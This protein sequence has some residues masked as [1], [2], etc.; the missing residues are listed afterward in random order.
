MPQRRFNWRSG[1]RIRSWLVSDVGAF[2]TAFG[3]E[4]KEITEMIIYCRGGMASHRT[5][6]SIGP[7]C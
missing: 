1:F 5:P 7:S 6:S 3:G 4:R 2:L